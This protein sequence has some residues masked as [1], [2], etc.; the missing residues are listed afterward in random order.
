MI[1]SIKWAYDLIRLKQMPQHILNHSRAVERIAVEIASHLEDKIDIRLVETGALLH[2]ICKIDSIRTGQD[3][4]RLGGRLLDILDCPELASIVRQ[5]VHL[6]SDELNEAM[7][8][9]YADKRVMHEE[10]VSLSRRFSDLMDRYGK[11]EKRQE[12]IFNL[13]A[14]SIEIEKIIVKETGIDAESLNFS[15]PM[16]GDGSLGAL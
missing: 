7:L 10:V 6:E 15:Y 13:Y 1:P 16:K 14:K 11:D 4:A 5:H 9:H 3:H 8:V 12:R 2:D